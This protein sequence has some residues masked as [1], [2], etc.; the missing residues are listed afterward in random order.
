MNPQSYGE[1]TLHSADPA[2]APKIDPKLLSHPFDRRVAIEAIRATMDYL[3]A[4]VFKKNTV[5]MIGC[6]KDRSDEAIWS[7]GFHLLSFWLAL[8]LRCRIVTSL[9]VSWIS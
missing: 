1:V 7:V 4:P 5:K 2:M 8:Y 3:D 6:P 9:F